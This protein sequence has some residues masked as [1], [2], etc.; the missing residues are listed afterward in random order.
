[1][2]HKTPES[3]ARFDQ[4]RLELSQR[5]GLKCHW[6]A[7]QMTLDRALSDSGQGLFRFATIEHMKPRMLGGT[8]DMENLRLAC[9]PCN[10]GRPL[11][12]RNTTIA[13]APGC[14]TDYTDYAVSVFLDSPKKAVEHMLRI[15]TCNRP[16]IPH[17]RTVENS[18]RAEK[19]P[20]PAKQVKIQKPSGGC[21]PCIEARFESLRVSGKPAFTSYGRAA[22]CLRNI[23]RSLG[24]YKPQPEDIHTFKAHYNF[25]VSECESEA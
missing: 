24:L 23:H 4:L 20:P 14:F 9:S 18:A 12:W 21:Q 2:P 22:D 6:C 25:Y 8:D 7:C 19:G 3:L 16:K 13:D 10:T 5:D 17:W 15:I 1:M 11:I